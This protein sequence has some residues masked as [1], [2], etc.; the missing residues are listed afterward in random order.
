MDD[1]VEANLTTIKSIKYPGSTGDSKLG[2]S[3][4]NSLANTRAAQGDAMNRNSRIFGRN[5]EPNERSSLV[6]YS[7]SHNNSMSNQ[8]EEEPF[9]ITDKQ[10][11]NLRLI[12]KHYCDQ[13][14]PVNNVKRDFDEI[15]KI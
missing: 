3:H 5:K 1:N 6:P 9:E 2:H 7:H 13:H 8:I 11:K 4:Y 14:Q 10:W 15:A 12:F